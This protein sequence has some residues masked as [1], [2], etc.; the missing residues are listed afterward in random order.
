MEL[1]ESGGDRAL[2]SLLNIL[3][4]MVHMGAGLGSQACTQRSEKE[5]LA[6]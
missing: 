3:E 2:R 6:L 4:E 5:L 1:K